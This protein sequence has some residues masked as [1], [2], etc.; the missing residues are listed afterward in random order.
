LETQ[1][2]FIEI[3]KTLIE[4]PKSNINV[5]QGRIGLTSSNDK[6]QLKEKE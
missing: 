3:Y 5:A 2:N 4:K 1:G 6:K